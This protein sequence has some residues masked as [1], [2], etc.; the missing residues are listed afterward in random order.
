MGQTMR[1]L[2]LSD[3]TAAR[4][5]LRCPLRLYWTN[6]HFQ[7]SFNI[8]IDIRIPLG[9]LGV[10][11]SRVFMSRMKTNRKA[12]LIPCCTLDVRLMRPPR[13]VLR[14]NQTQGKAPCL[15]PNLANGVYPLPSQVGFGNWLGLVF[16]VFTKTFLT[17]ELHRALPPQYHTCHRFHLLRTKTGSSDLAY[18]LKSPDVQG[19]SLEKSFM[20]P[21]GST[22]EQLPKS[23]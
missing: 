10:P 17:V 9:R 7:R 4:P 19:A 18:H 12:Q 22:D 2:R 23:L 21:K 11:P 6:Q 1:P 15:R 16:V 5:K 20:L 8:K 13:Q 14:S 3:T